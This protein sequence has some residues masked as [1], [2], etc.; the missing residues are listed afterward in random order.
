[1]TALFLSH[2][3]HPRI[4][5]FWVAVCFWQSLEIDRYCY[6]LRYRTPPY[7]D[8]SMINVVIVYALPIGLLIHTAMHLFFLGWIGIGTKTKQIFG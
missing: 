5:Y 2:I 1:M 7:F 6:V 3:D 4:M 8:S